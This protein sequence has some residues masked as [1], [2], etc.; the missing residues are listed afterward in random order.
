MSVV[1][2]K[3]T[4]INLK[5]WID[6]LK[7]ANMLYLLDSLRTASFSKSS[8]D[9]LSEFERKNINEGLDDIEHGRVISSGEFWNQLKNG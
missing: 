3:Q 6:Q 9:D 8:W 7:D 4:K 1:E 5:A 2:V